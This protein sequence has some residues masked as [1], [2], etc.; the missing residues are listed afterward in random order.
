MHITLIECISKKQNLYAGGIRVLLYFL[1]PT[2][3]LSV[4]TDSK[5]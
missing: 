4:L 1:Q 5:K 3:F 2:K